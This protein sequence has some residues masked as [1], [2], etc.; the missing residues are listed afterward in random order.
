MIIAALF[1]AGLGRLHT[2]AVCN[3]LRSMVVAGGHRIGRNGKLCMFRKQ[4]IA[5]D[6]TAAVGGKL[7]GSLLQP[8]LLV[9]QQGGFRQQLAADGAGGS[10]AEPVV[11]F[12]TGFLALYFSV[13]QI[14]AACAI[15]C[16]LLFLWIEIKKVRVE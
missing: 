6:H 15:L 5:V 2:Q 9:K 1:K 10:A 8:P 16:V 3:V 13:G 14:F 11:S 4:R 7:C 12:L